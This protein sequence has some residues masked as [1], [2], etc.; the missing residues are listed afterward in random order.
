MNRKLSLFYISGI[1]IDAEVGIE[2]A[3]EIDLALVAAMHRWVVELHK[4]VAW[5][6]PLA[7]AL[8]EVLVEEVN[9]TWLVQLL[10][11]ALGLVPEKQA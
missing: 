5:A 9:D 7:S 11:V 6:L 10:A 3:E 2:V 4:S 8:V 1:D